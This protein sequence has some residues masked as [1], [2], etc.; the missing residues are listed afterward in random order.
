M[1]DSLSSPPIFKEGI[2]FDG[3]VP[4][5]EDIGFTPRELSYRPEPG[6]RATD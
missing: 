3:T 2:P 4:E 5:L 1:R 6:E